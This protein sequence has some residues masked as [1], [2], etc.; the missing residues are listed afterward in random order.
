MNKIS[1]EFKKALLFSFFEY[2]IILLP[3]A[4]YVFL[5]AIHKNNLAFF[6]Q[7]AEWSIGII[8]L[9]F[10]SINKYIQSSYK[11]AKSAM[12]ESM[13]IYSLINIIVIVLATLNAVWSIESDTITLQICRLIL[14]LFASL[15]FFIFMINSKL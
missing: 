4:I 10:I 11:N 8:F 2:F 12:N 3:I 5:E 9:S 14:F 1:P 6:L 13:N 7:S 15:I